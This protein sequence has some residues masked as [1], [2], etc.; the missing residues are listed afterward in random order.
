MTILTIEYFTGMFNTSYCAH[1]FESYHIMIED[2]RRYKMRFVT[3]ALLFGYAYLHIKLTGVYTDTPLSDMANFSARL[4]F[5]QRL[6]V[7]AIVHF[8]NWFLPLSLY[9]LFFL[10]ERLFITLFYFA[11]VK[12]LA[13]E[14]HPRQAQLLSW[15][16]ILLLPLITVINYRF[17]WGGEATFFYPWDTASLFFMAMG[18]LLCLRKQWLYF[19][20]WVFIATFNRETGLLLVLMIPA[21]HW[22]NKRAVIS[23]FL[24]AILSYCLARFLVLTIVHDLPGT[25]MEWYFRATSHTYYEANLAWLFQDLNIFLFLFCFAGLPLFWFAFYDF[26]PLHY[27]PL[28]YVALFYFVVLLLVGNMMETRVFNE[29]LVILYLPV[30]VAISRWLNQQKPYPINHQ[31]LVFYINR[32]AIFGVLFVLTVFRQQL[33]VWVIWLSHYFYH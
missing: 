21:L 8:L 26:I 31:G 22:Q 6:L 30:C 33:D 18:F 24:L 11:L 16:F 1:L 15:L 5:G 25:I 10:V 27:R 23:V 19:I 7:P 20:P 28:R 4:P 32:Y 2:L 9:H 12:L 14:F 17:T 29:I 3:F 13:Y